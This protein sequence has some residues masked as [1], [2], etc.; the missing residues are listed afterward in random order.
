[1]QSKITILILFLF[2][3]ISFSKEELAIVTKS[4]GLVD[5]K[6][7]SSDVF[8][9]NVKSGL[10]L[11]NDD[12]L[13]TGDDGF[14]MFVYL[15]DGSLIKVHKNS[16]VYITGK[17]Q[18]SNIN[19]RINAGDGFFRFDVKEQK[20]DEFTVVTPSSVASVKGTDFVIDIGPEGDI[21]YGFD[22]VVDISNKI[23]NTKLRLEKDNK[24]E[25]FK[26]GNISSEVMTNQDYIIIESISFFKI[27]Q[28]T[29]LIKF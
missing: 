12:L 16:E 1:M 8:L 29:I 6:K 19:K 13:K 17:I 27:K 20:G 11:Y 5:Y 15:D 23:S 25:S 21:F 28:E 3:N 18:G 4:K 9:N 10:E 22:G 26:S 24:V 7:K 2:L 14:V